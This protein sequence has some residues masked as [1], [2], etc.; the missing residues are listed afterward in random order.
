MVE[1][2]TSRYRSARAV[3]PPRSASTRSPHAW[4]AALTPRVAERIDWSSPWAPRRVALTPAPNH[5]GA[6]AACCAFGVE[7]REDRRRQR[8]RRVGVVVD[9]ERHA[10]LVRRRVVGDGAFASCGKTPWYATAGVGRRC[11]GRTTGRACARPRRRVAERLQQEGPLE[12]LLEDHRAVLQRKSEGR[13]HHRPRRMS[14]T[15]AHVYVVAFQP[16]RSGPVVSV[17]PPAAARR[18]RL[19][20]RPSARRR[21]RATACRHE[22][23]EIAVGLEAEVEAARRGGAKASALAANITSTRGVAPARAVKKSPPCEADSNAA[24]SASNH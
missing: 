11:R 20:S 6:D 13:R 3:F 9:D 21:P 4:K 22:D 10:A 17:G 14:R 1:W 5:P 15:S 18:R 23:V 7:R 12:A 2:V 16:P 24:K 19:G 8:A